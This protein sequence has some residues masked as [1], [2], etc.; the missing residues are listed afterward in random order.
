MKILNH[1]IARMYV[2]MILLLSIFATASSYALREVPLALIAAVISTSVAEAAITRFYL[3]RSPKIPYSAI[4][5]GLII[6][7]VAPINAPILLA[8]LAS[9]IAMLSKFFIKA[10]STNILNPGAIGLLIGL[11]AFGA[12]DQWWAAGNFNVFGVLIALTPIFIISAYEARRAVSGL[13]FVAVTII[14]SLIISRSAGLASISGLLA[15]LTSVNYLFAFVMVTDPKTSPH[16]K[17][18]QAL[19]G[20]G[21]ASAAAALVIYGI[22]YALLIALL[23]GNM[24]YATYRIRTGG[25]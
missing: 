3:K 10:K 20:G 1:H 17:G 6:G 22:P 18:L 12:G 13:S 11:A 7:S 21:V 25:R 24:L 16:N 14:I 2:L 9:A 19:F 8:V 4:I 5:T 15:V 23:A